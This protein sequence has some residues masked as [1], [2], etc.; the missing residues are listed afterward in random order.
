MTVTLYGEPERLDKVPPA[1]STVIVLSGIIGPAI[2]VSD[3]VSIYLELIHKRIIRRL[4]LRIA[5]ENFPGV[6]Q[7]LLLPGSYVYCVSLAWWESQL[8]RIRW[9]ISLNSRSN[10]DGSWFWRYLFLLSST[11]LSLGVC[12]FSCGG[13]VV[14]LSKGAK[15]CQ[16]KEHTS[17]CSVILQYIQDGWSL[18][19]MDDS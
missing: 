19:R 1:L 16:F 8:H 4:S 5:Y 10:G 14:R 6:G 15:I 7:L 11:L 3:S 13:S 17:W 12:V 2:Q 18:D 9:Q